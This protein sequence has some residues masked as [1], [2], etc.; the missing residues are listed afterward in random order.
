M[1]GTGPWAYETVPAGT[2]GR[3]QPEPPVQAGGVDARR[4]DV[5][6]LGDGEL[7]GLHRGRRSGADA[8]GRAASGR[9][10]SALQGSRRAVVPA[11]AGAPGKLAAVKSRDSNNTAMH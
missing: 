9:R 1:C 3:P 10:Q 2:D 5:E 6:D 8:G 4:T 7:P 11:L